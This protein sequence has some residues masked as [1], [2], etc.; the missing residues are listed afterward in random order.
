MDAMHTAVYPMRLVTKLTGLTSD[1][2]RAWERRYKAIEPERI[3]LGGPVFD[4]E[5]LTWLNGKH[6]RAT[7]PAGLLER[8]R[9]AGAFRDGF[10]DSISGL[11]APDDAAD[12]LTVDLC[13]NHVGR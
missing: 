13:E 7:E 12:I 5:K 4:L 3:T 9:G 11:S 10:S 6:I 2:I 1:T 8:L